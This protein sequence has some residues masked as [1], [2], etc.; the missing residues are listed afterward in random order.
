MAITTG[1]TVFGEE[2]N[3]VKIEDILLHNF[4]EAEEVSITKD[5]TLILGGKSEQAELEKR[6]AKMNSNSKTRMN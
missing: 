3:L 5:D 4:G 2:S 1:G 6:I